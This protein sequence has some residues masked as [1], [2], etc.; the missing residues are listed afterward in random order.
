[1]ARPTRHMRLKRSLLLAAACIAAPAFAG[2]NVWT[3]EYSLT[4]QELQTELDKRFPATLRYAE[5]VSVQLSHPRLVLDEASNRL[6]THVDAR[7]TNALLPSPPV[8]GKLALNSGI[9]YDPAR[10]AVLLDNPTV[11]QVDVT[12]MALYREQLNAIGAVVAQQLLKD[13]PIYTFKPEELRVGGREVEP[14]AI[15]VGKDE[16]RVEVKQR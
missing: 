15:T 4:R 2:Y 9:R 16:V 14:G 12:G 10:R 7:L 1:M 13:Y 5:V 8:N 6:T 11:Q 3:G